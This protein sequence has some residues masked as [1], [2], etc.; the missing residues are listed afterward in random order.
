MLKQTRKSQ[1]P[2]PDG[3]NDKANSDL[4]DR[5]LKLTRMVN[6]ISDI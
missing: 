2:S 5:R 4:D 6:N 3:A 1:V